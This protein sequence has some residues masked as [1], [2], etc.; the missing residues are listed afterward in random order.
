MP[1]HFKKDDKVKVISGKAKDSEGRI[2]RVLRDKGKVIIEGVN[3]GKKHMKPNRENEK[4]G[5]ID[6]EMPVAISN[7]MLINPKSNK[8]VKV[9]K[10]VGADGKRVRIEKKSGNPID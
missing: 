10:K 1:I 8:P 9:A 6:K 4:G 5:I 3:K 7:I 2:I